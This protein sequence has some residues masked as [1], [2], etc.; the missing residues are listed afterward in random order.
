MKVKIVTIAIGLTL[1]VSSVRGNQILDFVETGE[2]HFAVLLNNLPWPHVTISTQVSTFGESYLIT[3][4]EGYSFAGAFPVEIDEPG[5]PPVFSPNGE[6]VGI[7]T[8]FINVDVE[9][10]TMRWD[11]EGE[12]NAGPSHN[13]PSTVIG[14]VMGPN[15]EMF[16]VRLLDAPE[17]SSTLS[18]LGI[19]LAGLA[20]FAR[21][22]KLTG[23]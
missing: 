20:W 6:K 5:S 18:L 19:G 22:R 3:L 2:G 8:N 11:S 10:G 7:H 12:T 16:D 15:G 17:P 23:A 21:I 4:D 9:E 13:N 1:A 14:G